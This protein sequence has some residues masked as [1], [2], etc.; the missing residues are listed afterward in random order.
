MKVLHIMEEILRL[1]R[2]HNSLML[3]MEAED[4]DTQYLLG[5]NHGLQLAFDLVKQIDEK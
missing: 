4:K 1:Q 3:K 5:V 2:E